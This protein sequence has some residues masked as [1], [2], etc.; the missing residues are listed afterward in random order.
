MEDRR[1]SGETDDGE[2]TAADQE[3]EEADDDEFDPFA[4]RHVDPA[5][6]HE[7]DDRVHERD[8]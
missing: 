2:D 1:T 8:A 3:D 5:P 4:D 7:G 6:E